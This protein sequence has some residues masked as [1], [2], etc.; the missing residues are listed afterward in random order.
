MNSFK[1]CRILITGAA[2]GIGRATAMFLAGNGAEIVAVDLDKERM[3]SLVDS[4][5]V[6]KY[7]IIPIVQDLRQESL[8]L[9]FDKAVNDAVKLDGMVHCAGI[10]GVIPLKGLSRGRLHEVMDINFYSFIELV[11]QYSK[12]KYSNGGSIVG[13]SSLAAIQ[14]RPYETA[15]IAS[16]AAMN[17]AIPCLA[18]E[19]K[20]R[21]IR[22]NGIM[23]GVVDTG[24]INLSGTDGKEDFIRKL[25]D[26]AILGV[27]KPED[28]VDVIVFLL[29]DYSR[30]ITGR[31]IPA[32][33]GM[34]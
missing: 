32:D 23:P 12:K 19:L 17:A 30:V 7:P 8:E 9:L 22:I 18:S 24:M 2:S 13:I 25:A 28:I 33:G 4:F 15:Y 29:S 10:A 6:H 1:D 27:S 31:V 34:I 16:K 5:N 20:N 26:K 3:S 11:R 21:G 14:P